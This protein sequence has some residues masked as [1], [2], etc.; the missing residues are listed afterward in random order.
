MFVAADHNVGY[1]ELV[2][3]DNFVNLHLLVLPHRLVRF[4]RAQVT[5]L[6]RCASHLDDRI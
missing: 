1:S 2:L 5:S 3:L 6:L 4:P